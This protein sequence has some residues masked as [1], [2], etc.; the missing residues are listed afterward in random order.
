MSFRT[1]TTT[2]HSTPRGPFRVFQHQVSIADQLAFLGSVKRHLEP[3]G[4]LVFDVFNPN[5]AALLAAD[6]VERED[7]TRTM[8]PDGRSF[9]RAAR[10]N[11]VRWVDQVSEIE[12]VYY[13]SNELG[14]ETDRLAQAF[15]MRWFLPAELT[16]VLE[17]SGFAVSSIYGA[18]DRSPLTDSSPEIVVI[19]ELIP[20]SC[21]SFP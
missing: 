17:R 5:F 13:L 8:L 1:S 14:D 19:S 2:C 16:H 4:R 15:D 7:T 11:R 10:V 20:F 12:I 18:F 6:G 9:R 21:S 3:G